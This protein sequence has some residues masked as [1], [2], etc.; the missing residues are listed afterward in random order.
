MSNY[1]NDPNFIEA[2]YEIA[3]GGKALKY[4]EEEES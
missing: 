1:P 2:I 4:D 3:F